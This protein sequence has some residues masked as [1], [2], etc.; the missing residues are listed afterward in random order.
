MANRDDHDALGALF[1]GLSVLVSAAAAG[2][3]PTLGELLGGV[4]GGVLG[5]R[6]PDVLEPAVHPNHRKVAHSF[7]AAALTGRFVVPAAHRLHADGATQ[8]ESKLDPAL[9]FLQQFAAGASVG[10]V[11]GY[12]SHLVADASTPKGLPLLGF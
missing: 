9:K 1:G 2:R 6:I 8:A 12:G 4:A 5:S 10:A 7:A 11:A 3:E